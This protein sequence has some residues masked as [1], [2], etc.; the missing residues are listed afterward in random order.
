MTTRRYAIRQLEVGIGCL[1]AAFGVGLCFSCHWCMCGHL[2]HGDSHDKTFW[3]KYWLTEPVQYLGLVIAGVLGI[4]GGF[5]LARTTGILAMVIAV[6]NSFLGISGY[7]CFVTP[8]FAACG[9]GHVLFAR[10]SLI[11][12][13]SVGGIPPGE[14]ATNAEQI[15]TQIP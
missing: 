10:D 6:A 12:T 7:G 8:M 13:Q 14:S 15:G 3:I 9:L 11:A 1:I 4:R 2:A 5:P